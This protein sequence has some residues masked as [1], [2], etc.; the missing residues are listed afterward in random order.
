MV[1]GGETKH[2]CLWSAHYG[3]DPTELLW[4]VTNTSFFQA[5]GIPHAR[6]HLWLSWWLVLSGTPQS[7]GSTHLISWPWQGF[8]M[9]F[10]RITSPS[11]GA[12]CWGHLEIL[13]QDP[14]NWYSHTVVCPQLWFISELTTD[15]FLQQAPQGRK[16]FHSLKDT[17]HLKGHLEE[18]LSLYFPPRGCSQGTY[19]QSLYSSTA[20]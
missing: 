6:H 8:L 11:G 7:S 1:S 14:V 13:Q 3:P 17:P 18:I 10:P 4:S 15:N 9:G 16:Y 20:R 2:E 5:D 12:Q 19:A